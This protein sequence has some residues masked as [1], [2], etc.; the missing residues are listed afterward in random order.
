LRPDRVV[1]AHTAVD[2]AADPST[3]DVLDQA[4]LFARGLASL[5]WPHTTIAVRG[6][7]IW[8]HAAAL[9]GAVACNLLEAPP[10]K[11]QLNAAATAAL[12]L[13]GVPFTGS[14]AGAVWLTTDKLAARAVLAAEGLPVAAG[15]RL[16]PGDDAALERVPPPWILKPG[17]ED[18]SVGLD[19]SPVATEREQAQARARLLAERFPAQP[20]L[21]E[22]FLPG[23]EFNV[24]LLESAGGV[25]TLPVAEIA[26]VDFPPGVPALVG[27]EAKWAAG[28]FEETHTVRRFP[29]DEDAALVARVRALATAAW[30]V[31]GLAGYGR[32]D[33]RLDE[34]GLP[35]VLEVNANPCLSPDAGFMAAAAEAGLSEADVVGRIVEAALRR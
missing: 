9:A 33:L 3:A 32:V 8:E 18:A 24:S 29:G 12:E 11:P 7:R 28:S 13:L 25:E 19:G 27:Y 17:W 30:R 21:V 16:D 5:G 34:T 23:R 15:G 2:P 10:G 26:F 35:V 6:G 31:C 14:P 1:V 22:H 4:R 20:V